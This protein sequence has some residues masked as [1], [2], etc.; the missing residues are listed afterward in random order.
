[1]NLMPNF[2]VES[3]VQSL[4]VKNNDMHMVIYLSSLI[5]SVIAL[6]D[7]VSNKIKYR[8]ED[9]LFDDVKKDTAAAVTATT[10]ATK[11]DKK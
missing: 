2:N 7:L 8:A 5:R 10:A 9:G 3:L 1:M 6:H 4:L 11:A